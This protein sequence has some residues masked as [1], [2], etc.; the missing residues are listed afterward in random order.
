MRQRLIEDYLKRSSVRIQMLEFLRGKGSYADVVRE[1]QEIVELAL[2]ALLMFVGL[3]VP[4]VHEVSRYIEKNINLFPQPIVDNLNNI[5]KIS[6]S[7]RKDR[8]LSFYGT[9]DWIPSDEYD[10][11]DAEQAILWSKEIYGLVKSAIGE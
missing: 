3:E 11:Q 5:K 7:L 2:K 4:K 1:A 8:E 6:R 9:E 10:L